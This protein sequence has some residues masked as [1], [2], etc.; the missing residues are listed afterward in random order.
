MRPPG[1]RSLIRRVILSLLFLVASSLL[2]APYTASAQLSS[3]DACKDVLQLNFRD[4]FLDIRSESRSAAYYYWFCQNSARTVN[5][6]ISLGLDVPLPGGFALPLDLSTE[7]ISASQKAICT[8]TWEQNQ[9]NSDR[10]VARDTLS[11]YAATAIHA[12]EQ[13]MTTQRTS[14]RPSALPAFRVEPGLARGNWKV[15]IEAKEG[16]I[17]EVWFW[18]R[19]ATCD[20]LPANNAVGKLASNRTY[21]CRRASGAS[22]TCPGGNAVTGY[23]EFTVTGVA[24]YPADPDSRSG[25]PQ[26]FPMESVY[27]PPIEAACTCGEANES[28]NLMSNPNHC[29]ACGNKC[30]AGACYAGK[31]VPEFCAT[32]AYDFS[33]GKC[34]EYQIPIDSSPHG[35]GTAILSVSLKS[36]STGKITLTIDG[37]AHPSLPGTLG[38][39]EACDYDGKLSLVVNNQAV[40]SFPVSFRTNVHGGARSNGF[41]GT[42]TDDSA[43]KAM[44]SAGV[45]DVVLRLDESKKACDLSWHT[46]RCPVDWAA[47]PSAGTTTSVIASTP[48]ARPV[49]RIRIQ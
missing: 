4:H 47:M 24:R 10:R 43:G 44:T 28:I 41:G 31:C 13:C 30:S 5:D 35:A 25:K 19:G 3:P 7:S 11:S 1:Q 14:Q 32:G 42:F 8:T 40:R 16:P 37:E 9:F 33:T 15:T 38:C 18:P 34:S 6:S 49:V 21:Y 22:L 36:A 2:V 29:G 48:G 39:G 20:A 17:P 12:W 23:P 27:A 26:D 46:P 45:I